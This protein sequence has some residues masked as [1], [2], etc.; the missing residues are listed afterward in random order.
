MSVGTVAAPVAA[1]QAGQ[2]V[3]S[4]VKR[5]GGGH[6]HGHG[7]DAVENQ[8]LTGS[9]TGTSATGSTSGVNSLA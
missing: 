3:A 1:G 8:A 9:V 4:S 6:H 2:A 5:H 7:A